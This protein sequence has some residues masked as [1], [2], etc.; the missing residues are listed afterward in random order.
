MSTDIVDLAGERSAL[1]E[2]RRAVTAKLERIERIEGG[3][4][5][6]LADEYIGA[7]IAGTIEKLRQDLVV[8]G[9]IDDD[10]T[11]RIGL[12]GIDDGAANQLVI[13]WRTTFA[14]AFY[15]ARFD[16]P[17]GLT[18]RVA[19]VGCIADLLIEDFERGEVS[20]SSPLMAE[21]SRRRGTEMRTAVATL[22]TE[23]DDLVRLPPDATLVLRGGPGTGKTVV[24]LH[25]AA[26]LVYHDTRISADRVLV[27]GP[28]D[29]FLDYVAS[30]LPTLG[31]ARIHQTTFER[32][33]G[34]S[35]AAGSDERWLDALDRFEAQLIT[36]AAISVGART[37]PE[38]DVAHA[39]ER[40]GGLALP[41]RDRRKLFLDRLAKLPGARAASRTELAKAA[42]PVFPA[43]TTTGALRRLRSRPTLKRLGLDAE[44]IDAW[45]DE[46]TDGALA[47]EV[48]ARFEGV[49]ARYAHVIVD[50]AQDM[51]LLQLRAVQRRSKGLMLVGDDAQRS[52][53]WGL[54]L[55]RA[56]RIL[57]VEPTELRTAYRMSAEITHWLNDHAAEHGIDAIELDG[58]R[59]TGVAVTDIEDVESSRRDLASRWD[60]VAVISPGE[61]WE[62]KGIE[63][64]A[65]IVDTVGTGRPMEPSEIYLA[66]S[67]AAHELHIVR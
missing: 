7:V 35:C 10:A 9:R 48:R 43:L 22:Q 12:Y 8:F 61:V 3:G 38:S 1:E 26:W 52:T 63:Y 6:S 67:R 27:L 60:T 25:R 65:V 13:D 19:Y 46:E 17:M 57:E 21:L 15:Q 58:I 16:E 51:S 41:W 42:A 2:A 24:A 44:L 31:E 14:A 18:R 47:D 45:L 30:V 5:D 39:L 55:R 66:A 33:L 20:G 11:W 54:G 36:P 23:Q 4:A 28:S 50:E 62:H 56:G 34:S 49:P 37:L 29:R 64:D 32:L 40:V 53:P 59:P